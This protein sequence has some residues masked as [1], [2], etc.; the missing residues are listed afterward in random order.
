MGGEAIVGH[1]FGVLGTLT[2]MVDGIASGPVP[3]DWR[4]RTMATATNRNL[5]AEGGS[6]EIVWAP[7]H[8]VSPFNRYGRHREK[9]GPEGV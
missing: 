3:K 8:L 7:S 6:R 1:G 2:C 4:E 9:S 5:A